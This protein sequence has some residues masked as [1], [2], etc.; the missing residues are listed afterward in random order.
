MLIKL[1]TPAMKLY[2]K[3]NINVR[4]HWQREFCTIREPFRKVCVTFL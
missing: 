1:K 3:I 2:V 4:N